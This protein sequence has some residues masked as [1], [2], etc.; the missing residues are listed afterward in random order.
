M[1]RAVQY[2]IPP[3][4][5]VK[6]NVTQ[7]VVEFEQQYYSP[8]DL[9]LFF[10]QMGLPTDTPV[11]LIGNVLILYPSRVKRLF[12][13]KATG[14]NNASN[15]GGE[16]TLDIEY[17]MGVAPGTYLIPLVST[18]FTQAEL[19]QPY[20]QGAPTTFWSIDLPS[21][22]G[23]DP[24]LEWAIQM[25]NTDN[26]KDAPV[27]DDEVFRRP[28]LTVSCTITYSSSGQQHQLRCGGDPGGQVPGEGLPRSLRLRI[29]EARPS[30][31]LRTHCLRRQRRRRSGYPPSPVSTLCL[32]TVLTPLHL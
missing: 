9:T 2:N 4:T 11:P 14:P 32:F 15:P 26:R 31:N 20:L 3:N 19:S 24:I 1:I 16:A 12:L 10:E 18:F 29:Q 5:L 7:C 6:T 17:I 27:H 30:W 25:S 13:K 28:L 23:A 8:D 21:P 22:G